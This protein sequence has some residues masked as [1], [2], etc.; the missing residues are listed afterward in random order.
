MKTLFTDKYD[1]LDRTLKQI[2]GVLYDQ[3]H[4]DHESVAKIMGIVMEKDIQGDQIERM[5]GR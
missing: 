2:E 3:K 5:W 4:G 1:L